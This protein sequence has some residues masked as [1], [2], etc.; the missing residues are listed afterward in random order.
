MYHFGHGAQTEGEGSV[1]LTYSLF[2]KN[3]NNVCNVKRGNL[4]KY[5]RSTVPFRKGSTVL[6][7]YFRA[8][9]NSFSGVDS[10]FH[11]PKFGKGYGAK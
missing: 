10:P 7:A 1:Q 11:Q 9:T 3:V 5:R 6:V 4:N 8:R 2:C